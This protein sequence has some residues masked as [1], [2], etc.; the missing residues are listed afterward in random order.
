MSNETETPERAEV[1]RRLTAWVVELVPGCE[2]SALAEA[3]SLTDFAGFDSIAIVQLLAKAEAEFG[4]DLADQDQAIA[5]ASTIG[6]LAD[7]I[8]RLR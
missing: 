7:T 6:S 8:L 5:S 1:A 2:E 3:T 4:V